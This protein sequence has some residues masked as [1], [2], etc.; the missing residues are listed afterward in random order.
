[1]S[2]NTFAWPRDCRGAV[3]LTYDDGL[4][5]HH[6]HVGPLLEKC[7]L[8]GTFNVNICTSSTALA[9]VPTDIQLNP[10][11]W[12][13]LAA[14]G[15]ELGNHTLFHPCRSEPGRDKSSW[16]DPAY[17]LCHYTPRRWSDEMRVASFLLKLIDGREHRTFANT[18]CDL[19]LGRD[20]TRSSLDPLIAE[21]FVGAR[22][23]LNNTP[24]DPAAANFQALGHFSGDHHTFEQLRDE[25]E[26]A[27]AA[28][29]W[30]IYMFHG[31]GDA[32]HRL[33]ISVE[34]HRKLAEW[35]G[36]QS[37]RIWTAPMIDVA[38]HVRG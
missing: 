2:N 15:H 25:I 13:D 6:G 7:G 27:V 14:R 5:E 20:E 28:G 11:A 26:S 8:R 19:D 16:M 17:N 34:E 38:L 36:S 9:G 31:V 18:C 4:P 10:Q 12:R 37:G 22:G 1:M 33:H 23:P 35:L 29:R 3:S 32:S 24:V 21:Q 30:I